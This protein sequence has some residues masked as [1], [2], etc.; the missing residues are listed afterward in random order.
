MHRPA[1]RAARTLSAVLAVALL[2]LALLHFGSY[3]VSRLCFLFSS[4]TGDYDLGP[5]PP[6]SGLWCLLG[7]APFAIIYFILRWATRE[8]V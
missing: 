3:L 2:C 1:V 6:V 5:L 7:A 8:H 4:L